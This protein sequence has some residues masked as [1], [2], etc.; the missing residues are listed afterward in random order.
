MTELMALELS[1]KDRL[2]LG[3][4][5][6]TQGS[7]TNLKLVRQAR[8]ALSFDEAENALLKFREVDS[9][10]GKTLAW[11]DGAVAPRAIVLGDV[12]TGLIAE[13]LRELDR[14]AQLTEELSSLYERFV[15]SQNPRKA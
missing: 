2:I 12:V 13:K 6:P 8:E 5:L 10:G 4:L 14:K 3:Q 7:Y 9:P 15:E 11:T 1:V